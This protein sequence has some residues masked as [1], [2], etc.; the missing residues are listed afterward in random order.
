MT[1]KELDWDVSKGT[2]LGTSTRKLL[3][4]SIKS[5]L[6]LLSSVTLSMAK[7]TMLKIKETTRG[8]EINANKSIPLKPHLLKNA[9]PAFYHLHLTADHNRVIHPLN[10]AAYVNI[11]AT[12][13][14]I[15]RLLRVSGSLTNSHRRAS[16]A[17]VGVKVMAVGQNWADKMTIT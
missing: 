7:T 5:P 9:C 1:P 12:M 14:M 13:I 17:P 10:V 2:G 6:L 3:Q 4:Q 8:K 11:E 15:E 16:I